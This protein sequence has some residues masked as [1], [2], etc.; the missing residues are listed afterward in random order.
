METLFNAQNIYRREIFQTVNGGL[1]RRLHEKAQEAV[2]CCTSAIDGSIE[3]T[4][5]FHF[6]LRKGENSGEIG[7]VVRGGNLAPH[8]C[9]S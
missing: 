3:D 4:F 9:I 8:R 6:L 5:F 1:I 7:V 2:Y